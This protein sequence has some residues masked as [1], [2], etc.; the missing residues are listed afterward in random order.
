MRLAPARRASGACSRSGHNE[1]AYPKESPSMNHFLSTLAGHFRS[2]PA[3]KPARR[4]IRSLQLRLE[5][6]EDRTVP[7][8]LFADATAD[9]PPP[10]GTPPPVSPGNGQ[11]PGAPLPGGGSLFYAEDAKLGGFAWF[12][13]AHGWFPE[14]L[15]SRNAVSPGHKAVD[16]A[17]ADQGSMTF[18]NVNVSTAGA[19]E[20]TFRYGFGPGL[21]PGITDRQM[22]LSVNGQVVVDPMHFPIT[23]SSRYSSS[24]A[25]VRLNQ[26]QNVISLFNISEHGVARV[27]TMTVTPQAP[28]NGSLVLAISPGGRATGS[29]VADTD[30]SS[31]SV[32]HGTRAA[33][34][35]SGLTNPPPERVLRHGR[36][37]NFK[38]TIPNLTPGATYTVR[39]DFVEYAFNT[40]GARV[41]NVAINGTQVLSNFDIWVAAGGQH[42]ALARSFTATAS[43]AG[44][45]TIGFHS[46]V[47]NSIVNGIE[48]YAP[49]Q[50]ALV[51][52]RRVEPGET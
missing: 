40:A 20:V 52:R 38:Y 21:F 34:N 19:Y 36:Y 22:G 14:V 4:A 7:S 39:L 46:V 28:A 42:V 23:S 1:F 45:I 37:G 25:L 27:D 10:P 5:V 31:G 2:A 15:H 8:T 47:N 35:T 43:T 26:G 33:I 24:S 30:F 12:D 16:M 9:P 11:V 32:S 18:F 49:S 17:Y 13:R 6:L 41:F 3:R 44:T 48:I 50:A 51:G 29:F